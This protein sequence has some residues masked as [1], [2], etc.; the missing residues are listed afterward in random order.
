M[1]KIERGQELVTKINLLKFELMASGFY[2]TAHLIDIASQEIGWEMQGQTAPE[3][4]KERQQE[5]LTP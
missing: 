4:Q 5:T 3:W 2:R 1:T